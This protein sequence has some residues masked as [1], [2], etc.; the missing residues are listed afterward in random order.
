[1]SDSGRRT[2]KELLAMKSRKRLGFTLIELLVV[3]AIIAVLIALLLPAVQ[4]AREAARRTQCRN[5]LK[6]LGLAMHNYHEAHRVF[7]PGIC[8]TNNSNGPA[9]NQPTSC[10]YVA[11]GTTCNLPTLSNA[12]AL[13]LVL[14]FMEERALYNAYNMRLACCSMQNSTSTTGIVKSYICPSNE[15][16]ETKIT[17]AYYTAADVGATDYILSAGGVALLTCASPYA[18]NT[19][20]VTG[21][22]GPFRPA[23]GAFNVNSN[24]SIRSFRDGTSQTFLMGEGAGGAQLPVGNNLYNFTFAGPMGV[25]GNAILDLSLA[26]DTP[27]SQ[28]YI[29][30]A[31]GAPGNNIGGFG[32]MFGVTAHDAWFNV[33]GSLANPGPDTTAPAGF[34]PIKMNVAKNRWTRGTAYT[35]NLPFGITGLFTSKPIGALTGLSVSGFRSY[36][37]AS[38]Q[39]LYGDGSVQTLNENIDARVYVSLSSISGKEVVDPQT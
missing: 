24:V 38:A 36:H 5:N 27:W 3:I 20:A 31:T 7:P 28:G 6:Q 12:S 26:V 16:G 23:V 11:A 33:Q 13:T 8:S 4:Q 34:T 37:A 9:L 39:F 1:M 25:D 18:L 32:S 19:M 35:T 15:R 10:I 14:P 30:N 29:G 17:A 2:E 21:Y 22:P